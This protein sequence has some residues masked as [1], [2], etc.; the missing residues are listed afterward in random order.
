MSKHEP[1]YQKQH[2]ISQVYLKQFGYKKENEYWLSVQ[3]IGNKKTENVLI[4]DFTTETNIFDL[5]IDDFEIK[6]H[7]E[8]LSGEVENFYRTVIS[9][10]HNQKMLTGKNKDVLNHFVANL[11]CRTN[12]FRTF[13]NDLLSDNESRELL[14]KEVTMYS[15][16]ADN[17]KMVLE[18]FGIDYQL[19]IF[20]GT[21]MNHLVHVFRN[22][23]KVIIR[24]YQ[25]HGWI[26]TDNPVFIDRQNNYQWLIP[27]ESE[28][29]LP[30]SKDFCLFMYHPNSELK[31]NSLRN[32]RTDKVNTI[33]FDKFESISLE[34]G[35][36]FYEYL[37][38]C[39]EMDNDSI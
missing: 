26:T 2:R 23:K 19:N 7:F 36:N 3:K 30:L 24:D 35:R 29:Y 37:I 21:V 32:L 16:D 11:L 10:L 33:S 6:R 13:I 8:N 27:I 15:N 14:I 9:N 39:T 25:N 38:F 20:I 4:K 31:T 5:P 17:N 12:P 34:I 18:H 1:E 22:F 28:I